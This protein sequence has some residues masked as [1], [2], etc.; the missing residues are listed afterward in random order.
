VRSPI[1][2]R[3][4]GERKSAVAGTPVSAPLEGRVLASNFR[5]WSRRRLLSVPRRT[6]VGFDGLGISLIAA[7]PRKAH[8]AS[9]RGAGPVFNV[10]GGLRSSNLPAIWRPAAAIWSSFE[11]KAS[12]GLGF[13][14]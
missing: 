11:E 12:Y 1:P 4:L 2:S 5:P 14:R 7:D 6:A 9:A 3:S 13:S 8:E 10:A